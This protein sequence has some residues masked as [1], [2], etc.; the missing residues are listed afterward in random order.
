MSYE[1]SRLVIAIPTLPEGGAHRRADVEDAWDRHTCEPIAVIFSESRETWCAGLNSVWEQVRDPAPGLFVLGS[2]DMVPADD[3]WLPP[4][5][6]Y[7]E[8]GVLPAP[9]VVDSTSVSDGGHPKQMPDGA[10]S[11][12][13]SFIVI[14]G[15]WGDTVFPLPEA[16]HYFGSNLV[17]ARLWHAGITCAA[18][19][20]SR[21]MRLSTMQVESARS[22]TEEIR[23]RVDAER[24]ARALAELGIDQASLPQGLRA[25]VLG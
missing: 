11:D 5:V 20:D 24:Y 25:P 21:I 14:D 7:I 12:L 17:C 13:A 4:L 8:R 15:E 19:P 2:D 1:E 3:N 6:Q 18:V 10:S 16:L 9:R 23:R 22:Q